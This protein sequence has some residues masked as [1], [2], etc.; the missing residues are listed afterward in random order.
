M[1]TALLV[2]VLLMIML[3][4]QFMRLHMSS[5]CQVIP[6]DSFGIQ[7]RDV[8]C[9]DGR[10]QTLILPDP[11]TMKFF[12]ANNGQRYASIVTPKVATVARNQFDCQELNG[13]QLENQPTGE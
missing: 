3:T 5:G 8:V 4:L 1:N 2:K 13:A 9:V 7:E 10:E 12:I 11:N 6:I